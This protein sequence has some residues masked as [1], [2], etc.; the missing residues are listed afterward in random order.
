[1]NKKVNCVLGIILLAI[2]GPL[3]LK[4]VFGLFKLIIGLALIGLGGY[5][6]YK[7]FRK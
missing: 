7:M 3:F 6:L 4:M 5:F 2:I 1:M